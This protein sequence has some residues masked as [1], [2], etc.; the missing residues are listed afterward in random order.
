MLSQRDSCD[1]KVVMQRWTTSSLSWCRWDTTTNCK[2]S[3]RN[4][5]A[6]DEWW[7]C[8][9][10][11]IGLY[12]SS[13]NFSHRFFSSSIWYSEDNSILTRNGMLAARVNSSKQVFYLFHFL[14]WKWNFL[15][16]LL[17]K[18]RRHHCLKDGRR[19]RQN[20]FVNVEFSFLYQQHQVTH[21]PRF[22]EI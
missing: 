12:V 14:P 16:V 5:C 18:V 2:A 13:T 4:V 22:R 20:G 19:N 17:F 6:A 8:V 9:I 3:S 11:V 15:R 10:V 21:L 1:T 7:C